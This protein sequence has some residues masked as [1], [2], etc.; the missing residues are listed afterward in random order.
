M[1]DLFAFKF[2]I[3]QILKPVKP[4]EPFN[5]NNIRSLLVITYN[6]SMFV[7]ILIDLGNKSYFF[8]SLRSLKKG[9]KYHFI[10]FSAF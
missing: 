1:K 2:N 5:K 9:Q 4:Y 8:R 7:E 6:A 10:S 3:N